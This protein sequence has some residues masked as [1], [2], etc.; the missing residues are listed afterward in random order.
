MVESPFAAPP[1]KFTIAFAANDIEDLNNRLDKARWPLTDTVPD[2]R[3]GEGGDA[4]TAFGMG[5][6]E[7]N[8][9]VSII[10]IIS[11]TLS[12]TL[13]AYLNISHSSAGH[14]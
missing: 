6:G 3:P 7:N 1:T 13:F 10:R 14:S 2:D 4:P 9:D 8:Q 5:Y 12:H 11:L